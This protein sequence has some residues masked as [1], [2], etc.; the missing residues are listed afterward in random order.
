MR[1]NIPSRAEDKEITQ[2]GGGVLR[3][4]CENTKNGWVDV[5]L[6]NTPDIY[7]LFKGVFVWDVAA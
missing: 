3:F 6:G 4:G 1:R 2:R 5:V 7:E